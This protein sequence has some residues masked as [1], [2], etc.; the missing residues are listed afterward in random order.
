MYNR[1]QGF[2][3][4]C[5]SC[6]CEAGFSS[7]GPVGDPFYAYKTTSATHVAAHFSFGQKT[8]AGT[9]MAKAA[10][11]AHRSL[12][13]VQSEFANPILK[14]LDIAEVSATHSNLVAS[15]DDSRSQGC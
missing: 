12:S 13:D 3:F 8:R 9:L 11:K 10:C 1:R 2:H 5:L 7:G 4:Q 15:I 6:P 14:T